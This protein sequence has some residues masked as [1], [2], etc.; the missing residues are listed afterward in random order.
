MFKKKTI[1]SVSG[2]IQLYYSNSSTFKMITSQIFDLTYLVYSPMHPSPVTAIANIFI[3]LKLPFFSC[4]TM[5]NSCV[6]KE[7]PDEICIIWVKKKKIFQINI[8]T[9]YFYC[10]PF[11]NCNFSVKLCKICENMIYCIYV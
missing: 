3:M 2:R 10:A 5:E 9:E 6:S 8:T 1:V 4:L 7:Y 11:P